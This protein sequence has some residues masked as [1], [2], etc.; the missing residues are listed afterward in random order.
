VFHD[1]CTN[2]TIILRRSASLVKEIK[3]LIQLVM[4]KNDH[5]MYQEVFI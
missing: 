2:I 5:T 3:P 4:T 1:I